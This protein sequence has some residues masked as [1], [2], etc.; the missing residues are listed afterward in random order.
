M[1]DLLARDW[2]SERESEALVQPFT[3]LEVLNAI[4]SFPSG[5]EPGPDGLP[6][7]FNRAQ[8]LTPL[9]ASL[10][11]QYLTEGKL[12]TSIYHVYLILIHKSPKILN[13]V[14]PTGPLL[15]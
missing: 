4:Q 6:I 5:K 1:L 2:F 12:P 10:Y 13:P 8:I 15:C 11:T 9:L 14:L 3:A 7:D